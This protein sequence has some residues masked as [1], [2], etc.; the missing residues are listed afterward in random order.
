MTYSSGKNSPTTYTFENQHHT[1]KDS[2]QGDTER[3]PA[4]GSVPREGVTKLWSSLS[5]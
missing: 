2:R 5:P 3:K 4:L 1:D